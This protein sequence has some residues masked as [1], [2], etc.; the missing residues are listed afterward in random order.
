MKMKKIMTFLL[1]AVT[2]LSFQSCHDSDGGGSGS[3][4]VLE[5]YKDSVIIDALTFQIPANSYIIGIN[6]DGDWTAEVADTSWVTLSNH[7]GYGYSDKWSYTRVSVTKNSGETRSTQLTIKAGNLTKVV[8][9]TQ[10]GAALDPGDPFESAYSFVENLVLG[11]NLGNTL[12]SSHDLTQSKSWFN[13]KTVYDWETAWG[14]P[15]T[16]QEMIDSIAAKGFN[17][18]RV[19]VTW[20]PHM[21]GDGNVNAAWMDRVEE[22]VNYVLNAGCYCIL[23]V[24]HDSG[25]KG[26]RTD[27]IAWIVADM[28]QYDAISPRYKYLWTQIATRFRD[29]NDKL[30]FEAFNEILDENYSWT[31]PNDA[32]AYTAVNL[33]EQDFVDAVRAT[34]G[35]NEYRN[36]VCNPYSAGNSQA[37]MDGW[38]PPTDIHP[39]HIL[40]SVHS[41]DPYNFCNDAGDYNVS[42]FDSDAQAEVDA[43]VSRVAKRYDDLGIPFFFG[44]FGAIDEDK[45]MTERIKYAT[46]TMS[47]IRANGTSGLW[48]MG[49]F[50]R[51]T[52][53][54]YE[55]EIVTALF[56]AARN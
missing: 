37:K 47:K 6:S 29:Y 17:A 24:M 32:S 54:W 13:P 44:E 1:L 30:L 25:D 35:N 18:I 34:G 11:Y 49:L 48:W 3:A 51:T 4:S 50:D 8:T 5:A 19:P 33:L 14:Q 56:E 40:G 20:F 41:Y 39:S 7:A 31:D 26:T 38:E 12:D 10:N 52:L 21:D 45:S 2:A 9:I 53:T 46:Y 28:D 16:T 36:L 23:N 55:D 15:V 22:V 42:V 27:S 43:V